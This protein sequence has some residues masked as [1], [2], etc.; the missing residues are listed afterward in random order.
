MNSAEEGSSADGVKWPRF[1]ANHD[2]RDT[3]SNNH[4]VLPS[5]LSRLRRFLEVGALDLLLKDDLNLGTSSC[6]SILC[7]GD[8]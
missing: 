7:I 3:E 4:F 6:R 8:L 5:E 1:L 2:Q